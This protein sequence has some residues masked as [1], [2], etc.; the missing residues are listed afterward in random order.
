MIQV[1]SEKIDIIRKLMK[2]VQDWQKSYDNQR[3]RD[4]EFS[5]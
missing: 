5:I 3:R 1:T 4:L 2:T